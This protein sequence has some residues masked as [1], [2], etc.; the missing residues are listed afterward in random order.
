MGNI[1][2]NFNNFIK[3]KNV[4]KT[5]EKPKEKIILTYHNCIKEIP[6][7]YTYFDFGNNNEQLFTDSSYIIAKV[8]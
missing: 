3:R 4:K 6:E 8:S 5:I 1:N 2:I 7:Y